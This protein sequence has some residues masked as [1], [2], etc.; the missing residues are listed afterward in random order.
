MSISIIDSFPNELLIR[1]SPEESVKELRLTCKKWKSL[2]EYK[3]SD[4]V[5]SYFVTMLL[6]QTLKMRPVKEIPPREIESFN[7]L[8]ESFKNYLWGNGIFLE[9]GKFVKEGRGWY[10]LTDKEFYINSDNSP[11]NLDADP[12]IAL[13]EPFLPFATENSLLLC[14]KYDFLIYKRAENGKFECEGRKDHIQI[15]NKYSLFFAALHAH[16]I[17]AIYFKNKRLRE[18]KWMIAIHSYNTLE[19]MIFD[20]DQ[21]PLFCAASNTSLATLLSDRKIYFIKGVDDLKNQ[22]SLH[23]IDL[24]PWVSRA[25]KIV[26]FF[27]SDH[28]MVVGIQK[29]KEKN[30]SLAIFRE[31]R[32]VDFI[33]NKNSHSKICLYKTVLCI[34]DPESD[35]LQ[36][37]DLR[38][39]RVP[40]VY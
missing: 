1:F 25:E 20:M 16:T 32:F 40:K 24:K 28:F 39:S 23:M 30:L 8:S 14:C 15:D 2:L 12:L 9:M 29:K 27:M 21:K 18:K 17:S 7:G 33:E 22:M 35:E 38:N 5:K 31:E 34:S 19:S 26:N 4:A 11:E 10:C 3:V 37:I 36:L 13:D 6:S